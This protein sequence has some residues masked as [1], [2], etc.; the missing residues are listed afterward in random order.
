M[1]RRLAVGL[2]LI[3]LTACSPARPHPAAAPSEWKTEGLARQV[4]SIAARAAPGVLGVAVMDLKSGEAWAYNGERRFPMQSV[5]KAPLAAAVLSEADAGRLSLDETVTLE[6][7]DLSAQHS[8]IAL[9]WPRRRDYTIEELVTHAVVHSDNTAADVLLARIGGPGGLT[10]WLREHKISG[11][12]IDRY[13]R[14]LQP[15]SVGMPSFRP[16]WRDRQTYQAAFEAI[17][18]AQHRDAFSAYLKD[19]RDTSTP[20]EMVMFLSRL[21]AGELISETSTAWLENAM[22]SSPRGKGRLA[23]GLPEGAKLAHKMGT[24]DTLYGVNAATN[25]VG[26]ATLPDGRRLAVAVFLSGATLP[27]EDRE[28]I[29]ADVMRAIVRIKG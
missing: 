29:I 6:E 5:F 18:E 22:S 3:F 2:A 25:D 19:T 14:Q 17:P 11:L 10:A 9:E 13:E 12:R 23:A 28:A 27:L 21:E 8:P 1:A 26:V 20:R 15:E 24:S 7:Q 16:E 4:E